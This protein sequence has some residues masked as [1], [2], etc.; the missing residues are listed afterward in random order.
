MSKLL[1][2]EHPLQ[3][4]PSLAVALGK[5]V[6]KAIILQQLHY[7]TIHPNA[8]DR[9]GRRWHYATYEAWQQQFPWV[10]EYTLG[11]HMR[12]LESQSLVT[13]MQPNKGKGDCTKWYSINYEELEKLCQQS[14]LQSPPPPSCKTQL[15]SLV[16]PTTLVGKTND[17]I[18]KETTKETTKENNIKDTLN[19][20]SQE[21]VEAFVAAVVEGEKEGLKRRGITVAPREEVT[22]EPEFNFQPNPTVITTE[23]DQK[24]AEEMIGEGVSK[25]VVSQLFR[26]YG[27]RAHI[28]QVLNKL[29]EAR[30]T[31][32]GV[33][34]PNGFM[35][36]V[37]KR[38][39]EPDSVI[40]KPV[41]INT[42]L[43]ATQKEIQASRDRDP[44]KEAL[45]NDPE[46]LERRMDSLWGALGRKKSES[47]MG[48]T[49]H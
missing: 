9:D 19:T 37:M 24:L 35:I 7:W 26:N 41:R 48:M 47:A 20:I 4:L 34:S 36:N 11:S 43:V 5:N 10:S 42:A 39:Y 28:R 8:P 1:I 13:S 30:K 17:V 40:K 32:R 38:P 16:K 25:D 33:G 2:N 21:T 15:P 49:A 46:K 31:P 45:V 6:E 14:G 29:I 22:F 18:R 27:D 23:A 12:W 3:A 44:I